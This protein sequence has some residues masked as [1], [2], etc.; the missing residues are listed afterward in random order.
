MR[1]L[2]KISLLLIPALTPAAF[3]G[4]IAVSSMNMAD[5]NMEGGAED[6]ANSSYGFSDPNQQVNSVFFTIY[7]ALL[8]PDSVTLNNT[9]SFLEIRYKPDGNPPETSKGT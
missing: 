3:A 4:R 7:K 5:Y 9:I 8:T 1:N 6:L 2:L